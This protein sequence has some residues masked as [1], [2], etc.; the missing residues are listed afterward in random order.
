[1]LLKWTISGAMFVASLLMG[2]TSF[3]QNNPMTIFNNT[4]CDVDI[5]L[6]IRTG[7]TC[8]AGKICK[9]TQKILVP[10]DNYTYVEP[11]CGS[12]HYWTKA[13]IYFGGN[14]YYIDCGPNTSS[15]YPW[16]AASGANLNFDWVGPD[17]IE[18]Q[19]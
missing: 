7:T 1:M 10:A 4:N 19:L 15:G 9:F 11:L 6:E 3:A 17:D 8:G 13:T 12:G 16:C 18:I 14:A 2:V 5:Q